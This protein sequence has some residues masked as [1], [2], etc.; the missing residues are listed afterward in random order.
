MLLIL[1]KRYA[2]QQIFLTVIGAI[3]W[4]KESRVG[5]RDEDAE[6]WRD[7]GGRRDDYKSGDAFCR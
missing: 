1:S 3:V 7:E 4:W 2:L 6:N 5:R